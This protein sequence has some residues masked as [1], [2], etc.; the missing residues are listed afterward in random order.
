MS[1]ID[2]LIRARELLR[3]CM[4]YVSMARMQGSYGADVLLQDMLAF[5]IEKPTVTRNMSTPESRAF[6]ENCEQRAE[7]L[8][9]R[10]PHWLL[11]TGCDG[12]KT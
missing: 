8:K 7:R 6:W 9:K 11:C 3:Q 1:A 10:A 2:D 4:G 5:G 12:C